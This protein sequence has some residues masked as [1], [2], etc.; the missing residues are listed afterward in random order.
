MCSF[1]DLLT[2][3]LF[4]PVSLTENPKTSPFNPPAWTL[5]MTSSPTSSSQIDSIRRD[6]FQFC[7]PP[8]KPSLCV[9]T[10]FLSFYPFISEGDVSLSS[11]SMPPSSHTNRHTWLALSMMNYG[12]FPY[13]FSLPLPAGSASTLN[14]SR[15]WLSLLPHC[16]HTQPQLPFVSSCCPLTADSGGGVNSSRCLL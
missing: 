16:S 2:Y 14:P 4:S 1:I 8:E 5:Q 10:P 11:R 9:P 12:L 6:L 7:T 13:T 15:R 3:L